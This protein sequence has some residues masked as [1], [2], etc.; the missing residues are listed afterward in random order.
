MAIQT[1]NLGVAPTGAG[2]DTFRSAAT[3]LNENFTNYAHAASRLVGTQAGNVMEVGA[4]GLG[5]KGAQFN[6]LS[7]ITDYYAQLKGKS[8]FYRNETASEM[9]IQ[10]AP[11]IYFVTGNTH[12]VIS[13]GH[14]TG[15]ILVSSWYED[16]TTPIV[17]S[18]KTNLNT[19]VDA[20]GF[21][22]NASPIVKLFTDRIE[23]NDE[24]EQQDISFEKL[25]VGDYLIKGSSGFAQ[26]GWYVETPKDANGNVLFSVLYETLENGDISVK[27]YKKK[28]DL[29]TASIVAD[30]D[31]PVD[32]TDGRWI[33]IRLQ[34]LPKPEIKIP[35]SA[36][37]PDFQ[38]TGLAQAVA[39]A[40]ESYN[41][42]K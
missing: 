21:I 25:G 19:T 9:T 22:K 29:E 10:Y 11:S 32:I 39:A 7:S 14:T 35:E 27:T 33:D 3:R 18:L 36:T 12:G 24:A 26:E 42:P 5:G 20:N 30:L 23:L 17:R 1:I 31:K 2:G 34:E 40:M 13:I 41:D 4:F 37:P 28:F 8:Q 38:P 15:E 16:L 6:N